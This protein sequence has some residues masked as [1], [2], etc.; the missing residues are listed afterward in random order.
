MHLN[1][2]EELKLSGNLPSPAGVGMRIL[3]ITRTEDYSAEE[4]GEAIMADSSLTGRILKLANTTSNSGLEPATTVSGA[5]MRL[6]GHTVRDLALAFSLVS[7]RSAG[8]CKGFEY[9]LYWSRSLARAVCAQV[10]TR[11]LGSGKPEEAY[12][13]GLLGEV[14]RLALA[15]VYAQQYAV[16]I[17]SIVGDDLPA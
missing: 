8:S 7:E 14:G 2:F 9:E 1:T 17:S 3:Q 5:I 6:G 11:V 16:I 15:S 4:M 13:C 10:I 12:I